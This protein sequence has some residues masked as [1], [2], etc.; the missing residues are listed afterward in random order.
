[1][2]AKGAGGFMSQARNLTGVTNSL[3]HIEETTHKLHCPIRSIRAPTAG[4]AQRHRR[5]ED[6]AENRWLEMVP[7][8]VVPA[9]VVPAE[10]VIVSNP[11]TTISEESQLHSVQQ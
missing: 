11:V 9:E 5:L 3:S 2:V 1:M 8:E 10:M 7:A 6:H 4:Q